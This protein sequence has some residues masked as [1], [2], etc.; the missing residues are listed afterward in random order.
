MDPAAITPQPPEP[1]RDLISSERVRF[2]TSWKLWL[3]ML[4]VAMLLIAASIVWPTYRR[5]R[6]IELIAARGGE[7]YFGDTRWPWLADRVGRLGIGFRQVEEIYLPE[8]VALNEF[9]SLLALDEITTLRLQVPRVKTG[10]IRAL[11]QFDQLDALY[12]DGEITTDGMEQLLEGLPN[13][14]YFY[15]GSVTGG[16]RLSGSELR[17]GGQELI[18]LSID[19]CPPQFTVDG[20]PT[21]ESV[22][23][24][25]MEDTELIVRSLPALQEVYLCYVNEGTVLTHDAPLVFLRYGELNV[26][27]FVVPPRIRRMQI[28]YGPQFGS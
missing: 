3:P 7:C 16:D 15:L 11:S 18:G 24:S 21:L 17:H 10:W 8:P 23:I 14:D 1:P 5:M 6:A 13:L 9:E 26:E 2:L 27:E 22:D 19:E 28:G 12:I 4:F 20:F 25:Q